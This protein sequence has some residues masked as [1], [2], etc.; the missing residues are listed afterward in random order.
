MA[1]W[2]PFSVVRFWCAYPLLNVGAMGL[3]ISKTSTWLKWG[4]ITADI[5]I[6]IKKESLVLRTFFYT[7]LFFLG[8]LAEVW[9]QLCG[10]T[11]V[12]RDGGQATT[13]SELG[14]R[15]PSWAFKQ[16]PANSWAARSRETW[17][18]GTQQSYTDISEPHKL[19][20][21]CLRTKLL[22]LGEYCYAAIDNLYNM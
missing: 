21:K 14:S 5:V 8:S 10:G 7:L 17:A 15:L 16:D 19:W 22:C 13:R 2:C 20:D 6:C 18:R 1:S 9:R 12:A 3:T 4:D 11:H